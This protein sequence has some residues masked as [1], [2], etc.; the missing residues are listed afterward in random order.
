MS[1]DNP[2]RRS[3]DH[4]KSEAQRRRGMMRMEDVFAASPVIAVLT[5]TDVRHAAPLARAFSE[6]LLAG[7]VLPV[8]KHIPGHGRATADSHLALPVIAD[9]RSSLETDFAP[10]RM[11]SPT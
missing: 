1:V 10:F 7:G 5:I 11:L 8:I 3:P 2:G 9:D 4:Q 6:G